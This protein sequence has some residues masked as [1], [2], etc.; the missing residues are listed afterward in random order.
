MHIRYPN[1]S[2]Y[3]DP[4]QSLIQST[5]FD[6]LFIA[7][8]TDYASEMIITN[9]QNVVNTKTAVYEVKDIFIS[10]YLGSDNFQG[11]YDGYFKRPRNFTIQASD[12][13]TVEEIVTQEILN[14]FRDFVKRYE[15]TFYNLKS[16]PI[17]IAPHN[18]VWMD[19][20]SGTFREGASCYIDAMR[21]DVKANEYELT[22]HV[23]NQTNDVTSTFAVKL[24]K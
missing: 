17:P 24:K 11:G 10:N 23:P 12:F 20:G 19:F 1:F 22:M 2:T 15:G 18:K 5:Y 8:K 13:P 9:T 4:S 21:Y 6:K 16:E 7:E 3:P 14:D